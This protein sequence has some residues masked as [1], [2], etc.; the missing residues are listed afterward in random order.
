[1]KRYRS[2]LPPL[3][4]FIF[5]EA[6]ARM[7]S[8]THSASELHV[9][10]AAVSNRIKEL[11]E[12]LKTPLFERDGRKLSLTKEG[13]TL[14]E[15]TAMA[16][17]FL[18]EACNATQRGQQ[19][20]AIRISA[21]SAVSHFWLGD[22]LRQLQLDGFEAQTIHQSSDRLSDLLDEDNDLAI[23]YGYGDTP[24]WSSKLLFEEVL[25]PVAAPEYLNNLESC[26]K[27]TLLDYE[28][29]GPD[30]TNWQNWI[31]ATGNTVYK[32]CRLL[33]CHSYVNA[34]GEAMKGQGIALGS[35]SLL[36]NQLASNQLQRV[37]HAEFKT[38]R[39]YYLAFNKR[40]K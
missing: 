33:T 29:K 14:Y 34:V 20:E 3:D 18:Q 2:T 31:E 17:E 22:R 19:V 40:K 25:F 11:E 8:F 27:A 16:L 30:W 12:I 24:G 28:R 7:R 15:K 10:Q 1:M 32:D 6:A 23:L 9:S 36:E 4:S 21:L 35:Y 38:N 5:F 26:S 39:G 13:Q 37:G